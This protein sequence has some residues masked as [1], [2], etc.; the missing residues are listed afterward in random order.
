MLAG[1]DEATSP[2]EIRPPLPDG[3]VFE[4]TDE[5]ALR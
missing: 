5:M 2:E 4:L 1:L 3:E